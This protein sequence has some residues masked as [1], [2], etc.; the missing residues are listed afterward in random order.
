MTVATGV[1]Q[2][3]ARCS[4]YAL[5]TWNEIQI[6][7]G[8][9]HRLLENAA[10]RVMEIDG[11]MSAFRPSGDIARLSRGAGHA[12]AV[13]HPD[14]FRLLQTAKTL[15]E[16][17]GG[18]FD[19]TVRPLVELWGIGKKPG[20]IPEREEIARTSRLVDFRDLILDPDSCTAFLKRPGQKAD[21]GG[22]AKGYAADE[23]RRI[24]AGGGVKSALINLG[25]NIVTLG[26]RPDGG[27]WRI[28]VQNP[29]AVR[30]EFLGTLPSAGRSI[31]TSGSN[32]QFFIKNGVRYHHILDPRTGAPAQSGL[33]SVT[34]A[35]AGSLE[36][37]ALSTAAFVLGIGKG[38]KL[39]EKWKAEAVFATAGGRIYL[40]KG[41]VH[42]FAAADEYRRRNFTG[43]QDERPE[44]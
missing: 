20:F 12:P 35:A 38:T 9:D 14:T 44:A 3:S 7:G 25:G 36:A 24:L 11:R 18:A 21:L 22:I 27:P 40:T 42:P 5:G 43:G 13:M 17:S 15:S 29:A 23:V 1:R 30:G 37:D 31:V 34:V 28:G 26:S 16:Q 41:L 19:I 32:E 6:C 33:L 10:R 8:F 4:F 39:L 2:E